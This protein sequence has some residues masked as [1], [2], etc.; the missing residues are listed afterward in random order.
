VT[1]N[2]TLII[3]LQYKRNVLSVYFV[4]NILLKANFH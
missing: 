3:L 1:K 2:I 4:Q